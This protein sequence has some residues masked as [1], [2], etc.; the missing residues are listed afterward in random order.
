[1]R[2]NQ[3]GTEV[4]EVFKFN[5]TVS[6]KDMTLRVELTK[7]YDPDI[8]NRYFFTANTPGKILS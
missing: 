6:I 2:Y 3:G 4:E 8:D 1:L 7:A 5:Q